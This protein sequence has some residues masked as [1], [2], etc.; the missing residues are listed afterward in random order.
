MNTLTNSKPV[1]LLT[2]IALVSAATL[3][4]IEYTTRERVAENELAY[5][6]Q[7][8]RAV[9][10]ET[11]YDN[12]PWSSGID[13]VDTTGK[14]LTVYPVMANTTLA[15]IVIE[16]ADNRG[17]VAPI[18]LLTA[19]AMSEAQPTIIGVR[20]AAHRETPGLGDK[21]EATRSDWILQFAGRSLTDPAAEG[22]ATRKD[23]GNFDQLSGATVTSRAVINGVNKSLAM[24]TANQQA[25][26]QAIDEQLATD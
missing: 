12:E 7:Q 16:T 10:A 8:L 22:W 2:L 18:K 15:A 1:V 11:N 3:S 23:G 4:R 6:S 25:I 21:I 9:L 13:I 20:V 26:D 5:K 14:P 19:I 24:L 17:Y